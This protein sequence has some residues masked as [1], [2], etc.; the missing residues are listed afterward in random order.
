MLSL[1]T[2]FADA[3]SWDPG[4]AWRF[5][6]ARLVQVDIDPAEIGR[7]YQWKS[8]RWRTPRWQ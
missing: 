4:F 5:P 2:R 7:S 1:G 8:A 6:P 3:S